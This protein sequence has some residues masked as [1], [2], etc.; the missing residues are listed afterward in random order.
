MWQ[1]QKRLLAEEQGDSEDKEAYSG[2][3]SSQGIVEV[4]VEPEPSTHTST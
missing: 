1:N 3:S 4:P 2:P